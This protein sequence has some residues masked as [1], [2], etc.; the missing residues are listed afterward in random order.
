MTKVLQVNATGNRCLTCPYVSNE[1]VVLRGSKGSVN[2][3]G[4]FNCVTRNIIYYIICKKC[5]DLYIGESERRLG[6]R[7]REHLGDIRRNKTPNKEVS[8]HF[9]SNGHSVSDIQ[10]CVISSINGNTLARKVKESFYIHKLGTVHPGGMNRDRG[11][12]YSN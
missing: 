7:F 5:G 11:I 2:H 6:D 10:V 12:V 8:V 3:T 1:Q 4:N 9:N